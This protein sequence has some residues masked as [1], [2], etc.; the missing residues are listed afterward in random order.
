MSDK[1]IVQKLKTEFSRDPELSKLQLNVSCEDCTV[2]LEGEAERWE[3]VVALGRLAAGVDG[4]RGVVNRAWPKSLPRPKKK[5]KIKEK[6]SWDG[7][8][9][10]VVIVG[11]GIVG[12]SIAR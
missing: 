1:E 9:V 4:V 5:R 12:A 11:A 2:H 7:M 6:A 3:Q 8:K 10:D